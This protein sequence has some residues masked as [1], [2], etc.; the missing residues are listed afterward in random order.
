MVISLPVVIQAPLQMLSECGEFKSQ[1]LIRAIYSWSCRGFGAS[2]TIVH[3]RHHRIW[4][5]I[6]L[7][8][9]AYLL[10]EFQNLL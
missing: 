7:F 3:I 5:L 10:A 1:A 9:R 2:L 6:L 4:I 8:D